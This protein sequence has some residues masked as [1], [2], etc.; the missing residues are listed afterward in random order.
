MRLWTD[1]G[2]WVLPGEVLA[3]GYPRTDAALAALA[4]AGITLIVNLDV[5]PHPPASLTRHGLVE[6]HLPTPDFTPPSLDALRRG[7]AAIEG[8]L[9]AGQRVA[10]HC[11][12]GRGRT[13]TLL[14]CLLVARGESAAGAIDEVRRRRPGSVETPE[15]EAAVHAFTME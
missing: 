7:V 4:A 3:C 2:S 8:A 15:Q 12:G 6:L 13:G 14:A 10:V 11:V 9:S 5:R 1:P